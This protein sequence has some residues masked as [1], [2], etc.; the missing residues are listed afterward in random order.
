MKT[1]YGYISKSG[2]VLSGNSPGHFHVTK[3][4]TGI[5]DV[6]FEPHF[7]STPAVV[8]TQVWKDSGDMGGNALDNVVLINV[9]TTMARFKT[10]DMDGIASDREF[11]FIALGE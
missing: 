11:S 7:Q 4:N 6:H 8:A 9:T 3:V 1:V 10:G 5:Y 2:S